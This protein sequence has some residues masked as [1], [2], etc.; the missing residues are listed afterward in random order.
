MAKKKEHNEADQTLDTEGLHYVDVLLPLAIHRP[1]TYVLPETMVSQ[2]E[3]GTGVAVQFGKQKVYSGIVV[4]SGAPKPKYQ[5]VKSVLEIVHPL[6]LIDK[7]Q[8]ELWQWIAD[9]Y[10]CSIGEVM[11]AA[12]PGGLKMSSETT[13]LLKEVDVLQDRMDDQEFLI[14]EALSIQKELSIADIQAIL[15]QKSVYPVLNRMVNKGWILLKEELQQTYKARMAKYVRIAEAFKR[16]EL[17]GAFELTKRSEKQSNALMV[18]YQ[19]SQSNQ[20]ILRSEV[21]EQAGVSLPVLK[22]LEKKGI[23]ELYELEVSRLDRAGDAEAAMH[24]LTAEQ[25]RALEEI[26][27]AWE[28]KSVCLLHGVTG[29]GKTRIYIDLIQDCINQGKQALYLLPEIALS[30]QIIKRLKAIFGKDIIAYH[31]RLGSGERVETWKAVREGLPIVIGVRSSI[32]LPYQ[33]LG[34]IIVDESHD[35]SFKQQNPAPRYNARDTAIYYGIRSD[36]KILLGTATPSVESYYNATHGKYGLVSLQERIGN[37]KMPEINI[38]DLKRAAKRREMYSLFSQELLDAITAELLNQQQ[39][40]L[41]QNR[42]GYAPIH[43][44]VLCDWSARCTNCDVSLT[45]HKYAH[46]MRCHYCGYSEQP[47]SACPECG[48]PEVKIIGFGTEKIE[49]ELK[50]FFPDARIKRMDYDTVR[51]KNAHSQLIQAFEAK[52]IDILVGTQMVTKGLDFDA[53]GLV[54]VLNAD[55]QLYYPDF[56][57]AER[58]FQLLTQVSGRAGRRSQ[59]GKVIIQS[60]RPSHPVIQFVM[61]QDY[62]A[63]FDQEIMERQRFAYPPFARMIQITFKHREAKVVFAA[64]KYFS[65]QFRANI[66]VPMA[67]PAVPYVPRIRNMYL[68]DLLLKVPRSGNILAAVKRAIELCSQAMKKQKGMSTVRVNVDVDPM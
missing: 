29:S 13:V 46:K 50:I 49:D 4:E 17:E 53:V 35:P 12:L 67:G 8:Y 3:F 28:E 20:D 7:A 59:V 25:V 39:V 31:S 43:Q 52:E 18:L 33:D 16:E 42:R 10:A 9:Y 47:K 34:L 51:Q 63:F 21:Y 55:Q 15:D 19:L 40:I 54:G 26:R 1:Y 60:G 64:A 38:V 66:Q 44:C 62:K 11:T 37:I 5:Q 61:D 23:I 27:L 6:P 14:A 22:A 32:F 30:A 2:V 45:Y 68:A 58:G 65:D 48:N 56:R 41:F 57:S 24:D 36:A